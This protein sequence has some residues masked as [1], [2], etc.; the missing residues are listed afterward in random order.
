M[1]HLRRLLAIALGAVMAAVLAYAGILAWYDGERIRTAVTERMLTRHG[2]VLHIDRVDRSFSPRPLIRVRGLRVANAASP[3]HELVRIEAASFRIHPFSLIVDSLA[4][5]DIVI[6]RPRVTV[7]VD[8]EG[9]LYWDPLVKAVSE[10]LHRFDWSLHGFE[11]RNLKSTTRNVQRGND[12]LVAAKRI[13]GTMPSAADLTVVATDVQAN[14]ETTL[15]LRLTGT[16]RLKRVEL[17]RRDDDLPV[18]LTAKGSIGDKALNIEAVGGNL[19][20][21]D[22]QERDPLLATISLGN[23]AAQIDG[24]MSRDHLTRLDLFVSF[25]KARDGSR[26]GWSAGFNVSDPGRG[27]RISALRAK[28][29][30]SELAGEVDIGTRDGRRFVVGTVAVSNAD[31]PDEE[32]SARSPTGRSMA[33]V[34]PAG[35]LYSNL[36]DLSGKLDADLRFR[37]ENSTI[38]GVPFGQL[39]IHTMLDRGTLA[40]EADKASIGD[41]ALSASLSIT[42]S[43]G[44]TLLE[45]KAALRDAPLAA[46]IA[47]VDELDGVRGRFDGKLDLRATGEEAGAVLNSTSGRI[48]L[49]LEDG[50]M[51]DELATRIAG[52]VLTAMFADFDKNSTT[53]INCA[54]VHFSVD[55]GLARSQK[56][57]MDTD[58]FNLYG[59]G[60]IRLGEQRLDI[61]LLPR[62]KDFSLVSMQVPLRIVGPFDSVKF[63]PD[64]GEAVASLITPIEL[65]RE[66]D[67][68]CAP[69]AL[70]AAASD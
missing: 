36:L 6:E 22:P 21:G 50:A 44:Q 24:T 53:P 9:A 68:N 54:V 23:A 1:Q 40:V 10:W 39:A 60:E 48:I 58:A 42:P 2:I 38:F 33:D 67:T 19:L 69:P 31:Y 65:G 4:L 70:S 13:A 8:D 49:F 59:R 5:Q 29:L 11:V 66:D 34:L 26:P 52:D 64:M 15:P 12:F 46:L 43:E 18:T 14:L 3:D 51:P 37:A 17:G 27:W 16:A 57:I 45:M 30:D 55:Q 63:N 7:P 61:E 56:I 62:A 25:E 47:G 28:R 20:D 35:D 41:A 32:V